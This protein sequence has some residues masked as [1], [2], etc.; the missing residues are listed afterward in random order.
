MKVLKPVTVAV[1]VDL[2]HPHEQAAELS[3]SLPVIWSHMSNT[4]A[5]P[6]LT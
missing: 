1:C 6:Y 2:P 4:K 5:A 3:M